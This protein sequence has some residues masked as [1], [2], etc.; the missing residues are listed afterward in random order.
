MSDIIILGGSN[1]MLKGGWVDSLK[2]K[3]SQDSTVLNL[4]IGASTTAM[5]LYRLISSDQ[6]K[7]GSILV[8]EYSLNESNF[9]VSGQTVE[10]LLHHLEWLLIIC[11]RRNIRF[12][13]VLLYNRAEEEKE[14]LNK[15][16]RALF[17]L[18]ESY[19]VH[20]IDGQA[21][22]HQL[23]A[24]RTPDVNVWYRDNAHYSTSTP[25]VGTIAETVFNT[26]TR[27]APPRPSKTLAERFEHRDLSV[28]SPTSA[29]S[30]IFKNRVA[31]C[32]M[33][34]VES[35]LD[36]EARGSLLACILVASVNAGAIVIETES[37]RKGPF[38][39]QIFPAPDAPKRILK[40]V[41]PWDHRAD[42][43]RTE[44]LVRISNPYLGEVAPGKASPLK[45][46]VQNTFT[47][48]GQSDLPR[49]DGLVALLT[50]I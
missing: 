42:M 3:F 19:Q 35:R 21:I 22:L 39:T 25:F 24:T 18:F 29:N 23:A 32:I 11:F 5:G 1:S 43:L 14:K 46:T 50:E 47:W 8:W 30:R 16:R 2:A 7:D 44:S 13:P 31:E 49:D 41:I 20:W 38:S 6:V 36:I 10:S 34:S 17:E 15:Y 4:G 48:Q 40:H 45:P 33:H 28:I 37:G 26:L 9:F 12:L 27:A